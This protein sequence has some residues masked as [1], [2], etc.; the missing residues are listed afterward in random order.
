MPQHT[1]QP[2][3]QL[4]FAPRDFEPR[5]PSLWWG[6]A[7]AYCPALGPTGSTLFDQ[8]AYKRHGATGGLTLAT[9][10]STRLGRHSLLFDDVN[11]IAISNFPA[12]STFTLSVWCYTLATADPINYPLGVVIGNAGLFVNFG[13]TPWGFFDGT[14]VFSG[15]GTVTNQLCHLVVTKIGTAYALYRNGIQEA[16]GTG[17]NI[18]T[19][20]MRLGSRSDRHYSG[21]LL[22]VM[23][24]DR[25]LTP[26]DIRT[27]ALAPGIAYT[28]EDR[29]SYASVA[30]SFNRRRR[31]LIGS[32][33]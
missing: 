10:W 32:A 14:N 2:S 30:E 7:G 27:L 16:S 4:G 17:V 33:A 22:D 1:F 25:V 28:P 11:S 6:T 18:T 20:Q 15:T 21:D 13:G 23:V 31:V 3:Y 8:T 5:Y 12:L 29:R 24:Y 19:N 9:A 26:N